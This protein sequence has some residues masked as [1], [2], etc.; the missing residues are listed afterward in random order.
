MKSSALLLLLLSLPC[1]A[2]GPLTPPAGA[3][4]SLGSANA[5]TPGGQPQAT[6]KSLQQVEPRT[7]LQS[8]Q[9]GVTVNA[10]GGFTISAPGS[11]YL[12]QNLTITGSA[13]HGIVVLAS[14]VQLDLN[15]FTIRSNG[16]GAAI[17]NGV[18][19]GSTSPAVA[20]NQVTVRNGHIVSN[21]QPESPISWQ[22]KGFGYGVIAVN[23]DG[24]VKCE[25]L[26]FHMIGGTAVAGGPWMVVERCAV[27]TC[28]KGI[29]GSHISDSTVDNAF[30]GITTRGAAP[31]VSRCRVQSYGAGGK[32]IV[33]GEGA[34]ITDCTVDGGLGGTGIQTGSYALLSGCTVMMTGLNFESTAILADS[35]TVQSCSVSIATTAGNVTA[36]QCQS[37]MVVNSTARASTSNGTARAIV[38]QNAN[39]CTTFAGTNTITNRYNMPAAP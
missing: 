18:S 37:G 30:T 31:L 24:A 35:S 17:G 25:N 13:G 36:I 5:L 29:E 11:Y 15:G 34:R 16:T 6:M 4:P 21:S 1:L 27:S 2:Q 12:A 38:A 28:Y 33:G 8:G 23:V 10:N 20:V 7:P 19:L 9:T 26:T 3:D 14:G 32:G 39:G 22:D